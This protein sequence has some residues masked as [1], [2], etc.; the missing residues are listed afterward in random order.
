MTVFGMNNIFQ[1][2]SE[3]S[4]WREEEKEEKREALQGEDQR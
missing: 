4:K 3:R 2:H 1:Y